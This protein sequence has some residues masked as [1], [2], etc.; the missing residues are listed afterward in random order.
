MTKNPKIRIKNWQKFQH[1]KDRRPPWIK[2]YRELLDDIDW[3]NLSG[4][5]AKVLIMVWLIASE[6]DGAIPSADEIAWR[7]RLPEKDI[8]AAIIRLSGWFT[9]DDCHDGEQWS[10]RYVSKKLRLE[11]LDEAGNKCVNCGSG[12]RLEIDHIIPISQGGNGDKDNLQVLCRSC[13]RAKRTKSTRYDG[14]AH[15]ER[16]DTDLK[17][18]RSLETETETETEDIDIKKVSKDT[19]KDL[20]LIKRENELNQEAINSWN[21]FAERN[22]FAKVQKLTKSRKSKLQNRL[23]DCGGIDGWNHAL[24]KI[25]DSDYLMGSTGWRMNF[26]S[27]IGEKFFVKLMEGGHDTKKQSNEWTKAFSD[28]RGNME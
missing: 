7:I 12:L 14:Y 28:L 9:D 6:N 27:L 24:E 3:H 1:F 13:N 20:V 26:D 19:P 23:N 8:E 25:K 10:S 22:N 17:N 15:A 18:K 16:D 4:D 5:D 2:L 11:L 21:E